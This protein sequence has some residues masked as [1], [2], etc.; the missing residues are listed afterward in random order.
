MIIKHP[1]V[2]DVAVTGIPD[3]ESGD[4]PVAVVIARDGFTVL[5]QEIKDL[6][7]SKYYYAEYK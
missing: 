7:K 1:G 4:L 3:E 5:A 2:R 6:I